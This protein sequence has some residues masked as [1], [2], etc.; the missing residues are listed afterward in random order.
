MQDEVKYR[1]GASFLL[2]TLGRRA[3]RAWH[4]YLSEVGVT[5][6]QFTVM[7]VLAEGEKT[8]RELASAAAV[9]ARN[10]GVTVNTLVSA[11]RVQARPNP[12]DG[13]GR[14]LALTPTGRAWWEALQP[15]LADERSRFFAAL[16]AD[17]MTQLES[18]L[19]RLETGSKP[20]T[21]G[22]RT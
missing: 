2:A 22:A 5:T 11:G 17:E 16:T 10:I 12:A 21:S 15:R 3:E 19:H 8:Q 1:R 9:D 6:A 20:S 4:G 13:R 18:L 7:A 14:I